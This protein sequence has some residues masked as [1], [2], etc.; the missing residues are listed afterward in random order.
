[1]R[2]I[3]LKGMPTDYAE[4][5]SYHQVSQ[6]CTGLGCVPDVRCVS[7]APLI[8]LDERLSG[9]CM[10]AAWRSKFIIKSIHTR[11]CHIMSCQIT[12]NQFIYAKKTVCHVMSYHVI[13]CHGAADVDNDH[14]ND[15]HDDDDDDDGDV[16]DA[17][18]V[19]THTHTSSSILNSYAAAAT[20]R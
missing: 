15:D 19:H 1:M 17:L 20:C 10:A 6:P 8:D 3:L 14:E 12:A 18:E 7:S 13:S 5:C 11:S 4:L 9:L 2:L 16:D